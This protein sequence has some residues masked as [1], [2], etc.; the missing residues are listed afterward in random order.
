MTHPSFFV[1]HLVEKGETYKW[2]Y[3]LPLG[4][5]GG[6]KETNVAKYPK[7]LPLT[8]ADASAIL[9]RCSDQRLHPTLRAGGTWTRIQKTSKII[10]GFEPF[11]P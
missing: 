11:K 1:A 5:A 6:G 2:V 7:Y 3:V 10:K 4:N 9:L 8:F